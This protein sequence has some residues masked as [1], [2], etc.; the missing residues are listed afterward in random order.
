MF[1]YYFFGHGLWHSVILDSDRLTSVA[2]AV[3]TT[4]VTT[5]FV[6]AVV[7][8]AAVPTVVAAPYVAGMIWLI[9]N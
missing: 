5:V 8:V 3:V 1:N 6:A 7:S 4:V 2:A 9:S